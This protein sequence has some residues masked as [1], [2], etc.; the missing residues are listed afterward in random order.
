MIGVLNLAIGFNQWQ[1]TT[2]PASVDQQ[3]QQPIE[4]RDQDPT[5][6]SV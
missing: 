5:P 1:T 3:Q 2:S 4:T 6:I